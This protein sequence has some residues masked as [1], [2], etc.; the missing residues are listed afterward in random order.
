[1]NSLDNISQMPRIGKLEIENMAEGILDECWDGSYP[2]NIEAICDYLGIAIVPVSRLF[3]SFG[4]DAFI[5][6]DF[7]TIY[8]DESEFRK[9]SSRYRF[10]IAHEIGHFVLHR[11]YF[12]SR[13]DTLD[14]WAGAMTRGDC[15]YIE[16][17][18]N[19]FAGYLLA[20]E[21]EIVQV[22]NDE[23]GGSFARNYYRESRGKYEEVLCVMQ[24]MFYVSEQVIRRRMRDTI[25]GIGN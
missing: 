18:A 14:E 20:P 19:H 9:C 6:V 15:S 21:N 1:M 22:L 17:Q 11:E 13:V 4:V 5:A 12:P 25:Y 23:Y 7:R 16:Y 8:V 3:E 24:R 2:I 10:S